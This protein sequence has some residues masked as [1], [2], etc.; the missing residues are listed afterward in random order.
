MNS[1]QLT[2]RLTRD[3]ELRA[4]TTGDPVCGLRLAVDGMGRRNDVGY[5]D[6]TVYGKPGEACA[7]HLTRGWLVGVSGASSTAS[8][9]S[10]AGP[11]APRTRSSDRSTS[12]RRRE[13]PHRTPPGARGGMNPVP[14][15]APRRRA[16]GHGIDPDIDEL[17]AGA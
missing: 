12:L 17:P 13:R 16:P 2:G 6:V 10:K 9:K 5:I 15:G 14:G 11:S 7:R 8:G 4:T 3:P 1:I